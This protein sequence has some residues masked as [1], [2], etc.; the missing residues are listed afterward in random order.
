MPSGFTPKSWFLY[1][2]PPPPPLSLAEV[3]DPL[4]PFSPALDA[5]QHSSIILLLPYLA[6]RLNVMF[7]LC[8]TLTPNNKQITH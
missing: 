7:R 3:L 1:K 2:M 4:T 6:E 8:R 5:G